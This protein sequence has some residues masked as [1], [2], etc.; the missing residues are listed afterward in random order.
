MK[1]IAKNPIRDILSTKICLLVFLFASCASGAPPGRQNGRSLRIALVLSEQHAALT[2]RLHKHIAQLRGLKIR[3]SVLSWREF[4]AAYPR[5]D[6]VIYIA[7]HS[8]L[9]SKH[10]VD[11]WIGAENGLQD[12]LQNISGAG[13]EQNS[14][15]GPL[16]RLLRSRVLA[17]FRGPRSFIWLLFEQPAELER[18]RLRYRHLPFTSSNTGKA[19]LRKIFDEDLNAFVQN[20]K[21]LYVW[22]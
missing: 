11:K 12:G 7:L 2:M 5:Y 20:L 19:A 22:R 14:A 3:M 17:K 18:Y 10:F 21:E 13:Q 6:A 9:P 4:R 16:F 1:A 8:Q 15:E